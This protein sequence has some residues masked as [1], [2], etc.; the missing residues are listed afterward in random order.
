MF[1][2][3]HN[4][5]DLPR[6]AHIRHTWF[7]VWL[8]LGCS[9][10]PVGP[11]PGES[12]A[13]RVVRPAVVTGLVA[14][15]IDS[16]LVIDTGN[17]AGLVDRTVVTDG[18][19]HARIR[20]T[21]GRRAGLQ[22][23]GVAA[24]GL[25]RDTLHIHATVRP[26]PA[27]RILFYAD[28]LFFAVNDTVVQVPATVVD[29][30]DNSRVDAIAWASAASA[31]LTTARDTVFGRAPGTATL[32]A[33]AAGIP[34]TTIPARV[35]PWRIVRMP[36]PVALT[37][38]HVGDGWIHGRTAQ[39][40]DKLWRHTA[41]AGWRVDSASSFHGYW[42]S[43]SGVVWVWRA[44]SQPLSRSPRPAEWETVGLSASLQTESDKWSGLVPIGGRAET[45]M[46]YLRDTLWIRGPGSWTTL[47]PPPRN[48]DAQS[49]AVAADGIISIAR[50]R[51]GSLGVSRYSS[52]I[53]SELTPADANLT[54][55]HRM[56]AMS[57]GR[58]A[59]LTETVSTNICNP[60]QLAMAA[61]D[62]L[63]MLS[64]YS[65]GGL[66]VCVEDLSIDSEGAAILG[67]TT[68]FIRV[69]NGAEETFWLPKRSVAYGVAT[70]HLGRIYVSVADTRGNA[71][72]RLERVP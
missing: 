24:Q 23:I 5:L 65:I 53:W 20:W 55:F 41:A 1:M 14:A 60:G 28:T 17:G 18:D 56:A 42:S 57:G 39:F 4:P 30:F 45:P 67:R 72:L 61:G 51:A 64:V 37:D 63:R 13:L 50:F 21:L 52:G 58:V 71:I 68:G 10:Q 47:L 49:F 7:A 70:D 36:T 46:I 11:D 48:T 62:S 54:R 6:I 59:I 32:T 29:E 40:I 69:R 9:E 15:A 25:G 12:V 22:S 33:T 34:A 27:R 8:A 2:H 66:G 38:I 35:Q 3:D 19:G 44:G 31:A 26:G 43:A 16:D